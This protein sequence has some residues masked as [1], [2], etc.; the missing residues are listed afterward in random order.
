[1]IGWSNNCPKNRAQLVDRAMAGGDVLP[2]RPLRIGTVVSFCQRCPSGWFRFVKR[3]PS[4]RPRE[5]GGPEAGIWMFQSG[6]A[7]AGTNGECCFGIHIGGYL[8]NHWRDGH[9]HAPGA[10]VSF[11]SQHCRWRI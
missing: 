1:L 2:R 7:S 6:S 9:M 11:A 3:T 8:K 4:V 10:N 5:S